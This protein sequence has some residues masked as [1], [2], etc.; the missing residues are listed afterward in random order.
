MNQQRRDDAVGFL[1]CCI[2]VTLLVRDWF[3]AGFELQLEF[4]A[5]SFVIIGV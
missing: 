1:C 4:C 3:V 5:Y 2:V